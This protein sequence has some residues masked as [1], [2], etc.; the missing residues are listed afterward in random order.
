MTRDKDF[1]NLRP[2]QRLPVTTVELQRYF[3]P[4]EKQAEF[5]SAPAKLFGDAIVTES[6]HNR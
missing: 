3:S 5:G 1:F 2:A 6:L 4:V